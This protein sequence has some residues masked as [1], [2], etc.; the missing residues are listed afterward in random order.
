MVELSTR[1]RENTVDGRNHHDKMEHKRIS[2]AS[3]LTIPNMA[4]TSLIRWVITPIQGLLN[5]IRQ[6]VLLTAHIPLY[7]PYC[8]HI[9][10]PSLTFSSTILASLQE[11]K[12]KSSLSISPCHHH[13]L[14]LSAAYTK[15]SIHQ[16][17]HTWSTAYTEYSIHW[18]QHIPKIV[19]RPFI[20]TIWVDPWMYLHYL[21]YLPTDW[22]PPA[23]S[24]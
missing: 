23:S 15:C 17:Q 16:V 13:E 14:T 10:P 5:P 9:H 20:L 2:C 18:V 8:A 1:K 4:G 12:V 19:C 3:Q 7:P 11:H 21:V 22:P 24:P 6:G